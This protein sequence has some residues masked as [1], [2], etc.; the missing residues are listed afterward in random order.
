MVLDVKV[1]VNSDKASDIRPCLVLVA[2][3]HTQDTT[4]EVGSHE[5]DAQ[6]LQPQAEKITEKAEQ[7]PHADGP[8]Q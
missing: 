1:P 5:D 4:E 2:C 3:F 7:K 8:K 6:N